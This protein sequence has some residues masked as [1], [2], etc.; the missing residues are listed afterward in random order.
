MSCSGSYL[1]L[2]YITCFILTLGHLIRCRKT[3]LSSFLLQLDFN[4]YSIFLSEDEHVNEKHYL[5][6]YIYAN[7]N[8][9]KTNKIFIIL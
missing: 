4:Y 1:N 7:N 5:L 9:E 2:G 6:F 8:T 3:I